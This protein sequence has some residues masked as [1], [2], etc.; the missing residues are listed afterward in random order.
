MGLQV[1]V[2]SFWILFS[3][4]VSVWMSF[5]MAEKGS[6]NSYSETGSW[7]QRAKDT[8]GYKSFYSYGLKC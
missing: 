4:F 7:K 2:L 1:L 3:L 6:T 8:S 5:A